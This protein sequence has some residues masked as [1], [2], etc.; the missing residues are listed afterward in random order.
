MIEQLKK[1]C[2]QYI[3]DNKVQVL[4]EN[5]HLETSHCFSQNTTHI[6]SGK[7]CPDSALDK[8]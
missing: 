1:Y 8:N 2:F 4:V 6:C 5:F 7:N 3:M